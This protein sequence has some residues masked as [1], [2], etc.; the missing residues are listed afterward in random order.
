MKKKVSIRHLIIEVG[1][2]CNFACEH[3]YQGESRDISITADVVEA[4]CDSV[5]QID[6]LHLAGGEPMLYIN[7]LRMILKIFKKRRIRVNYLGITTNMS[8]RSQEFADVYNEWA[9][10]ITRPDESGLEVSIDP[11]H[12]EFITREKINQNIAFYREKCPQLKQKHNITVFDNTNDKVMYAEGR[13]QSKSKILQIIQKYNL[14]IVMGPPKHPNTGHMIKNNK[15][16]KPQRGNET[17]PCGYK[18]VE[19][20]IYTPSIVLFCDGSYAP[21]SAIPSKKLAEERGFIIGNVLKDNFFET[22]KPFNK[23]CKQVRNKYISATPIYLDINGIY[24]KVNKMANKAIFFAVIRDYDKAKKYR[25]D[26]ECHLDT[27]K[28]LSTYGYLIDPKNE[29]V[30]NKTFKSLSEKEKSELKN[31]P[32]FGNI[33]TRE[34]RQK[35]WKR[36]T[37]TYNVLSEIEK[38]IE[39][40]EED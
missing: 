39:Q 33:M 38:K 18:C 31:D 25:L 1:L 8:M 29:K 30:M 7:E 13:M 20:C 9:D 16:C 11:F 23:K 15:K 40:M 37:D 26:A 32:I 3:C 4:L 35:A 21:S 10:Y 17:N 19:N 24:N 2:R 6:E 34:E 27:L 22:I 28:N 36:M 14:D 12:L 5:Y